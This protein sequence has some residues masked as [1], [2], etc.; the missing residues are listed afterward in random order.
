MVAFFFFI[1]LPFATVLRGLSIA[2]FWN[3]FIAG[4]GAA[5]EGSAPMLSVIQALG[6]SLVVAFLTYEFQNDSDTDGADA[7]EIV[8]KGIAKSLGYFIMFWLMA[9]IYHSIMV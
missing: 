1:Y 4:Q 5:F 3:W 2:V 7:S 8:V 9:I 6:I